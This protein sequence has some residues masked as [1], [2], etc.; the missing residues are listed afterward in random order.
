MN[1][2]YEVFYFDNFIERYAAA[3]G[4][5]V[6]YLR[7]YGWNNSSN[8]DA[9]NASM[10]IYRDLLPTDLFTALKNSEFVFMEV[11]NIAETME[12]LETNFPE[13]QETTSI[14]ENYIH[15]TLYNSIGQTIISN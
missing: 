2:D 6:V 12:F 8:V 14:P 4:K 13:S 5:A 15:Y 3:K 7:S 9:I 11:D 1:T 10:D